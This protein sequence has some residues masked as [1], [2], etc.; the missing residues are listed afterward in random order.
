MGVIKGSGI[1]RSTSLAPDGHVTH[2]ALT[3]ARRPFSGFSFVLFCFCFLNLFLS[4]FLFFFTFS[5]NKKNNI[6]PF[7]LIFHLHRILSASPN[8]HVTHINRLPSFTAFFFLSPRS[9]D[10]YYRVLRRILWF[11]FTFLLFFFV[12]YLWPSLASMV[13]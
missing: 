5:I 6:F 11:F 10:R 13:A 7:F 8:G 1:R 3:L 4:L 12:K 9:R 2:I